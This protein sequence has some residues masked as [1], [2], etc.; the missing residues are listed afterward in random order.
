MGEW[1]ATVFGVALVRTLEVHCAQC[2]TAHTAPLRTLQVEGEALRLLSR[3]A[4]GDIAHLLRPG[5][6]A[7]LRKVL[8]DPEVRYTRVS[9]GSPQ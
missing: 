6:L 8:D 7:Q 5:H 1:L 2:R 3:T 9:Q 4:M